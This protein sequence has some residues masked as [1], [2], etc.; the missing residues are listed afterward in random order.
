MCT[1]LRVTGPHEELSSAILTISLAFSESIASI[2][3]RERNDA[4]YDGRSTFNLTVSNADGDY[5]PQQIVECESF[6]TEH[7]VELAMLRKLACVEDVCLDFMWSFPIHQIGQYNHFP[8]SLL[9]QCVEFG[10]ELCIS[11][12]G[13][14]RQN[15]S[16]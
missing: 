16:T 5:I 6:F 7:A 9:K 14:S 2:K 11:V 12:Y 4:S 15:E 1:V 13:T 10:V 8:C 3:A